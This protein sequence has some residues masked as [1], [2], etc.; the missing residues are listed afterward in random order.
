MYVD[1]P[2]TCPK[3]GAVE[4][5]FH[6]VFDG[7]NVVGLVKGQPKTF[8]QQAEL[9]AK[10]MGKEQMQ[11]MAQADKDRLSRA[12]SKLPGKR[13]DVPESPVT[14]WFRDGSIEGTERLE[15]PL[16]L[17]SVKDTEKYIQTGKKD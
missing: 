9:N 12:S 14:P 3:C 1:G 10:R 6:Q 4:P 13:I 8:G 2:A 15:K 7:G 5:D 16:N 11:L 17:S